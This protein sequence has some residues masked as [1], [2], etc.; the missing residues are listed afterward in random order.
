MNNKYCLKIL[1][2]ITIS[3]S[4][5]KLKAIYVF[6]IFFLLVSTFSNSIYAQNTQSLTWTGTSTTNGSGDGVTTAGA[7]DGEVGIT[8]VTTHSGPGEF[9]TGQ[10]TI[11]DGATSPDGY[12]QSGIIGT[13]ALLA[14]L[15]W[16]NNGSGVSTLTFTFDR[17][18]T[19]PVLHIDKLGGGS[20]PNTSTY[21]RANSALVTVTEIN[22]SAA[23][24]NSLTR[25]SG[26]GHFLVDETANE[27]RRQ[28]RDGSNNPINIG[29]PANYESSTDTNGGTACGSVRIIGTGITSITITVAQF[30][31]PGGTS[32]NDLMEWIWSF[33]QDL[34]DAPT[35]F[36]APIHNINEA[37]TSFPPQNPASQ[38]DRPTF[39]SIIHLGA[40]GPDD[41]VN[42][43]PN[44]T[45]NGDDN[46]GTDD[47]DGV[48][49]PTLVAGQ[50]GPHNVTVI[51]EDN[52]G[53]EYGATVYG[54]IDFDRNG[55]F[56][57][58]EFASGPSNDTNPTGTGTATLTFS[59]AG[60]TVSSTIGDI[61]S[62]F[63]ITTASLGAG[64]FAIVVNDGEVEDY[65]A[66]SVAAPT[67]ITANNDNG[68]VT[69]GIGGTA[70]TNVLINDDLGGNTPTV[71]T[72]DLTQLSTTNSGVTLDSAGAVN[73]TSAVPA[74]TYTVEYQICEATTSNCTTAFATVTVLGDADGD[75]VDD[76][77]DLDDDND[78]ILDTDEGLCATGDLTTTWTE[79]TAGVLYEATAGT[80]DID[81]AFTFVGNSGFDVSGG[82]Y[83]N[84]SF[85]T[86][87]FWNE[88]LSG[89]TSFEGRWNWDTAFDGV[90]DDIDL[91]GD[92]KG[93]GTMTITFSQPVEN[94][95]INFDRL[96]GWAQD[97]ASDPILSNSAQF[98]LT[99]AGASL[100]RLS[101]TDDF[102]V[103]ATTIQK[104]SDITV[105]GNGESAQTLTDGTASGSVKIY[106]TYSTLTFEFTGVGVEGNGRD[107]I[108]MIL[109]G[110]CPTVDTDS[111]G[112]PDYLD[113]D[114]DG[115]GCYDALEGN[116]GILASQLNVDGS[117]N[118]PV[119]DNGIP[120]GPGTAGAGTTGQADVSSTNNLVTGAQCQADL[121]LT[122]TIDNATPK[123]GDS[124]TYTLILTNSG[125]ADATGVRVEDIL[126]TGLTYDVG[127][128]T[129][130]AG[131]T[132]NDGTGIWD[133]ST[134]TITNGTT[135]TLQIAAIVTP[136][137]GELTNTAEI[138]SSNEQ[139][140]DSTTNNGI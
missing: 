7:G 5:V 105:L 118:N 18:V 81:V 47:E 77:T 96:G 30:E 87:T 136:A 25:L 48:T 116:G 124:I 28:T 63:R 27:I 133:L 40:T 59:G 79:T 82:T 23:A 45:S 62:R 31:D 33:N 53:T 35:G 73:V 122:K 114:S 24:S 78:G 57:A 54:W 125:P 119:N 14:R 102:D 69:T 84:G 95:V 17:A 13:S 128:S 44:A 19:N 100:T 94:P 29:N 65:V 121:S 85:N 68:N 2:Q 3:L 113:T 39:S 111:D 132:Y 120:V 55:T 56:D 90:Y 98:T 20:R 51:S 22:G 32:T 12:S 99:T 115:D 58:D 49:M 70:I 137:C 74:G 67:P 71:S 117:I 34:G 93:T 41:E 15:R 130:P 61:Y 43:Q 76:E 110:I 8:L 80:T 16:G 37:V 123:I 104:T 101:G 66:T 83:V 86:G 1:S 52:D 107:E 131:T 38:P 106:G 42:S 108:E 26:V 134:L 97:T 103:T 4:G 89:A 92:D 64:D 129:I 126:P 139:D 10:E 91:I 50:T 127:N 9:E 138:I 11:G 21:F 112:T 46:N 36:G 88:A 6:A 140:P 72:V 75:G 60:A 109:S 135:Y